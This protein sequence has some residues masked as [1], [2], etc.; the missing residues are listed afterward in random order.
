MHKVGCSVLNQNKFYFKPNHT[1]CGQELLWDLGDVGFPI[2]GIIQFR[3][4]CMFL[5][6]IYRS[7]INTLIQ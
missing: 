4:Y 5:R 6:L 2:R 7:I 3:C 1:H